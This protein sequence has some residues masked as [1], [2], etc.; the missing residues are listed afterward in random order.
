MV[1]EVVWVV[2]ASNSVK[3]AED[4]QEPAAS[5]AGG[6]RVNNWYSSAPGRLQG[7]IQYPPGSRSPAMRTCKSRYRVGEERQ[8]L[9]G[10]RW[11][12]AQCWQ[13]GWQADSA[14]ERR[15]SQRTGQGD[16]A[17]RGGKSK[18]G[19]GPR[20]WKVGRGYSHAP[21]VTTYQCQYRQNSFRSSLLAGWSRS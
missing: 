2:Q 10:W 21:E 13:A 11:F 17:I 20:V 1:P 9:S 6:G 18:E 16:W 3:P 4:E 7:L 14:P 19:R 5:Q 8:N 12:R 15:D